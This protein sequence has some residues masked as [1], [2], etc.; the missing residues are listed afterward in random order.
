MQVGNRDQSD[1]S[2][3]KKGGKNWLN[4]WR[5]AEAIPM[6]ESQGI[7]LDDVLNDPD[8]VV[9][10][11]SPIPFMKKDNMADKME[12][13][14]S[15]ENKTSE[16]NKRVPATEIDSDNGSDLMVPEVSKHVP[17]LAASLCGGLDTKNITPE[18]F[19]EK[20]LTYQGLIDLLNKDTN[21]S[22]NPNLVIRANEKYMSWNTAAPI[23]F[24]LLLYNQPLP[25]TLLK[26]LT[27]EALDANLDISPEDMKKIQEAV[28]PSWFGWFSGPK[29]KYYSELQRTEAS[30]Q[31]EHIDKELFNDIENRFSTE[32]IR[33]EEVENQNVSQ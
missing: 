28:K 8:K 33:V 25:E 13:T 32:E 12:E 27:K 23:L 18:K 16:M 22:S 3:D 24:S 14:E 4:P 1:E 20:I 31:T 15:A 26:T 21:L 17:D 11:I 19:E 10:Y 9:D 5:K 30:C 2:A 7:Y 29:A 6:A